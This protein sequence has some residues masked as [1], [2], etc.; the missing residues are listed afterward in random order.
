MG[1]NMNFFVSGEQI[2]KMFPMTDSDD[3]DDEQE[4]VV[5]KFKKAPKFR[6]LV[7]T[8]SND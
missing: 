1:I 6:E 2:Q 3:S 8:D 4:R 7:D 5:K